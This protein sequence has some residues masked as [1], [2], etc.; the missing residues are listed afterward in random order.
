M[1]APVNFQAW[2]FFQTILLT[3]P[4]ISQILHPSVEMSN[5]GSVH[6]WIEANGFSWDDKKAYKNVIEF[7]FKKEENTYQVA[8]PHMS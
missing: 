5:Q 4:T 8:E 3:F 2:N 1:H 6:P 7:W